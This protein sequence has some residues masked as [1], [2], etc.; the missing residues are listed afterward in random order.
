M[1]GSTGTLGVITYTF[2]ALPMHKLPTGERLR[3]R[4]E[5]LGV[6]TTVDNPTESAGAYAMFRGTVSDAELQRRVI[7]AE[8]RNFA[9][10]G[11]IMALASAIA[12]IVSAVTAIVAVVTLR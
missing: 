5:K 1:S 7:E 4:A 11:W 6:V 10:R 2:L 12:A 3:E 9:L 8:L